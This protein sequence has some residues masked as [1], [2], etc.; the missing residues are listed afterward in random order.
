M[1]RFRVQSGSGSGWP[2]AKLPTLLPR[3]LRRLLKHDVKI[4]LQG[5]LPVRIG[6]EE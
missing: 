5:S 6:I 3:V 2:R 4:L 1:V